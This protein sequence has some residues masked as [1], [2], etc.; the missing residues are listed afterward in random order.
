MR[1]VLRPGFTVARRDDEHL[2]VGLDPAVVLPET[3]AVRRL[4]EY[5]STP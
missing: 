3:A 1:H 5:E 2:Q 4:M